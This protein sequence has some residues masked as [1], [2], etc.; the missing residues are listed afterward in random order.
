MAI[1]ASNVGGCPEV[2]G[3]AAM[4]VSPGDVAA[5]RSRLLELVGSSDL[6]GRLGESA[7]KRVEQF[8]WPAVAGQYVRGYEQIIRQGIRKS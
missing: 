7:R 2:V 4:L 6:R 3:D 8:S 5:I 1:I